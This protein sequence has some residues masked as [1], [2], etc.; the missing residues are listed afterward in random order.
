MCCAGDGGV[1]LSRHVPC[2]GLARQRLLRAYISADP[3]LPGGCCCC[4]RPYLSACLHH[5]CFLNRSRARDDVSGVVG[6]AMVSYG[7]DQ[8][9]R[10]H[11]HGRDVRCCGRVASMHDGSWLRGSERKKGCLLTCLGDGGGI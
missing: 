1:P 10:S 7:V 8:M 3:S 4:C 11:G 6:E 5:I 2:Q 9:A